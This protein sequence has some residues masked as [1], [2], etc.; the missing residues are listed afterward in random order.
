MESHEKINPIYLQLEQ[1]KL[2]NQTSQVI[3]RDCPQHII[4]SLKSHFEAYIFTLQLQSSHIEDCEY[5]ATEKTCK[6]GFVHPESMVVR[7]RPRTQS[8]ES[9]V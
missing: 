4:D 5:D 9:A 7:Y 1:V 6:C 3:M 2:A 8:V